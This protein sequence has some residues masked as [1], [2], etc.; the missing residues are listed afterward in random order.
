MINFH[1]KLL[2]ILSAAALTACSGLPTDSTSTSLSGNITAS[3]S[4]Q[5]ALFPGGAKI[6]TSQSLLMG[7]GE[8]WIGR[9][10]LTLIQSSDAAYSFFLTDYPKQGWTLISAV[11]GKTSLLVFTK[12]DRSATVE[13]TEGMLLKSSQ[14]VITI[15]PKD[16]TTITPRKIVK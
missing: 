8:N 11:R 12:S 2:Y 14:A 9:A 13:V 15:T 16:A 6:D 3:Q 5:S 7:S 1:Q 4:L 10:V